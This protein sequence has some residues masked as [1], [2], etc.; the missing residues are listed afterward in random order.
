M[1]VYVRSQFSEK[2]SFQ[3]V[4]SKVDENGENT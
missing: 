3:V 1:T 2:E 4:E